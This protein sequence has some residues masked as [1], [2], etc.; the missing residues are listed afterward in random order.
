MNE[1]GFLLFKSKNYF[2]KHHII[3]KSVQKKFYTTK[4]FGTLHTQ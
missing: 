1:K 4:N 2:P 3:N